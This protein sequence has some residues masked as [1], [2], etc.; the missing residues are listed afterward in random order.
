ALPILNSSEQARVLRHSNYSRLYQR[1]AFHLTCQSFPGSE[2]KINMSVDS[3]AGRYTVLT[4]QSG[5]RCWLPVV[6]SNLQRPIY[7]ADLNLLVY[8][9]IVSLG[10]FRD[11]CRIYQHNISRA[12][13]TFCGL[14]P[15]I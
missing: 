9:E 13:L 14:S 8:N 12:F 11:Y 7:S 6:S 5:V 10:N 3:G 15:A 2:H 1:A 4:A